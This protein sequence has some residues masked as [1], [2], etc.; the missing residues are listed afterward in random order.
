MIYYVTICIKKNW[1]KFGKL[2]EEKNAPNIS[3]FPFTDLYYS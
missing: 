1:E 2:V 3:C